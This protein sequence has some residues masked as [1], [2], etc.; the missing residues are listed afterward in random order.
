MRGVVG[1]APGLSV[2]GLAGGIR[3]VAPRCIE[4]S[5]LLLPFEAVRGG[6]GAP[7][8]APGD[9][10]VARDLASNDASER[11]LRKKRDEESL[12][13]FMCSDYPVPLSHGESG[14]ASAERIRVAAFALHE[15]GHEVVLITPSYAGRPELNADAPF[16]VRSVLFKPKHLDIWQKSGPYLGFDY[17]VLDRNLSLKSRLL[18]SQMGP[19]DFDRMLLGCLAVFRLTSLTFGE[20]DAV[21]TSHAASAW[22]YVAANYPIRA[23][24]SES[25]AIPEGTEERIRDI[26][27]SG[28]RSVGG[29]I[30]F[31]KFASTN[32]AGNF[33]ITDEKR[34]KIINRGIDMGLFNSDTS[35]TKMD[36]MGL[37]AKE[38]AGLSPDK[39]WVTL[40]DQS[41]DPDASAYLRNVAWEIARDRPDTAVIIIDRRG[42]A[43]EASDGSTVKAIGAA[44]GNIHTILLTDRRDQRRLM[45]VADAGVIYVGTEAP[46]RAMDRAERNLKFASLTAVM[47][48]DEQ[49]RRFTFPGRVD[50]FEREVLDEARRD[51]QDYFTELSHKRRRNVLRYLDRIQQ[52]RTWIE[53]RSTN[54]W[55]GL[56]HAKGAVIGA[57]DLVAVRRLALAAGAGMVDPSLRVIIPDESKPQESL[58]PSDGGIARQ[59]EQIL[60]DAVKQDPR[61]A[62]GLTYQGSQHSAARQERLDDII[63]HP[64]VKRLWRR[65]VRDI[66]DGMPVGEAFRE[67]QDWVL[68]AIYTSEFRS[69]ADAEA[70]P[71]M[72]RNPNGVLSTMARLSGVTTEVLFEKLRAIAATP[73]QE[74]VRIDL[75]ERVSEPPTDP[76]GGAQRARGT[77]IPLRKAF[78]R[79]NG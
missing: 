42:L 52:E 16:P 59:L 35:L 40:F 44:R 10:Y 53:P 74:L 70:I 9:E 31:S 18:L 49:G 12:K 68:R 58:L 13:I 56:R 15:A 27:V 65:L 45:S 20:P 55:S 22:N 47:L 37:Y 72:L 8:G 78:A 36:L 50:P 60:Y 32:L 7:P 25:D 62:A 66:D 28:A 39:R 63:P 75:Q 73:W 14:S 23:F 19:E 61:M 48:R 76:V 54:G 77:L 17:P 6:A 11:S 79:G 34:I 33:G 3:S 4:G 26:I 30:A 71:N 41:N 38:L 69:P 24:T 1:T 64:D 21:I 5:Q 46:P 57:A 43:K 2:L 67:W 51:L 29:F